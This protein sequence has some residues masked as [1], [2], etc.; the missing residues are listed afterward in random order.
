MHR[1]IKSDY[2]AT[3]PQDMLYNPEGGEN[4]LW[5]RQR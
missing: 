5:V 3:I 2:E 1:Y 4:T